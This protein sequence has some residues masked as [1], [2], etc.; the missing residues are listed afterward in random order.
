MAGPPPAVAAVRAAVRRSLDD[1]PEGA[2]VLVACSGGA[3]SLAL[4]DALAFEGRAGR[5]HAGLV[6]VDH[7]L[8]PAAREVSARVIDWAAARGFDPAEIVA[9]QVG[10]DGGP[11]AAARDAR[12]RA[13]REAAAKHNAIVLLGHTRD[14]QAETVLLGLARGSG[15]RSLAGMPA[16]RGVF[17]R[18]LLDLPRETVRAAAPVDIAVW[19]DP[20]NTDP[21]YARSRLRAVM[22]ELSAVLGHDVSANLA[23]TARLLRDDADALDAIARQ[24]WGELSTPLDVAELAALPAAVRRRVLALAA[25]PGGV[26]SSHL[27]AMDALIT[28]WHGQG[29]VAL[30]RGRTA[31]RRRGKLH[32]ERAD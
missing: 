20:H 30:P 29:P 13:L 17:R 19:A 23:R 10:A 31:F 6:S 12:Y 24:R 3:D 21:R 2:A 32:L 25:G 28:Q 22:P 15:A 14:D 16:R 18:P 4:A 5:F 26:E 7:G 9:V 8:Q 27:D 11:E 1:L